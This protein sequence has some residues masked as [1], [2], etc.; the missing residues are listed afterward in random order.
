MDVHQDLL[1]WKNPDVP[2]FNTK[3]KMGDEKRALDNV[4]GSR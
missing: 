2:W 4:F 3:T 1:A